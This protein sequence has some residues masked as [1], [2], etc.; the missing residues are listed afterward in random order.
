[1]LRWWSGPT[2]FSRYRLVIREPVLKVRGV[3]SRRN[4]SLNVVV[5]HM[6]GISLD[7]ALPTIQELGLR[8]HVED[9]DRNGGVAPVAP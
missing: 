8:D 5:R 1:M 4:G 7:H 2:C 6:E 9:Q 3:V